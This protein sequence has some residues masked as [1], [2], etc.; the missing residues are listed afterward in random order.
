MILTL[1]LFASVGLQRAVM[2]F[3]SRTANFLDIAATACIL[4]SIIVASEIAHFSEVAS[5]LA[6]LMKNVV[7]AANL[8]VVLALI[9]AMAFPILKPILGALR[10][11]LRR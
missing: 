1:I 11:R 5:S 10:D 7:F 3:T 2:P 9:G 8:A 6:D 4:F